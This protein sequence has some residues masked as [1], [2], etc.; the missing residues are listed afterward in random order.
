MLH[1]IGYLS[2]GINTIHSGQAE[3]SI[4]SGS[5][6][7]LQVKEKL[8]FRNPKCKPLHTTIHPAQAAAETKSLRELRLSS[9][10]SVCP[11]RLC[12]CFI[13][14]SSYLTPTHTVCMHSYIYPPLW[15]DQGDFRKNYTY[16]Y[17]HNIHMWA[18]LVAQTG[19]SP[20]AVQETHVQSQSWED[21]LEK[22]MATHSSI[23]AWEI[24]WTEEPRRLQSMVLQRV[25]HNWATN[26]F[27]SHVCIQVW[28][29]MVMSIMTLKDSNQY[30]VNPFDLT[31]NPFP[32]TTLFYHPYSW[33]QKTATTH[34]SNLATAC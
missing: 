5:L 24:P 21:P 11:T 10:W 23:L 6:D 8:W 31:T 30:T 29:D 32:W 14:A 34:G 13:L 20:P 1:L 28:L 18:S 4:S 19:K 12:L 33:S 22:G 26:T 2:R 9:L 16:T 15:I 17:I 25:G 3:D 7:W 27:I